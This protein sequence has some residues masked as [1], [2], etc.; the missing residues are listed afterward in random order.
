MSSY[1]ELREELDKAFL[2]IQKGKWAKEDHRKV[3]AEI[4]K[5]IIDSLTPVL[6]TIATNSRIS[7]SELRKILSE[8][9]F[10]IPAPK[11]PDIDTSSI[12]DAITESIEAAFNNINIPAPQVDVKVPT[13][14]VSVQVPE[15]K[16]PQINIP[17]VNFP[18]VM[19]TEIMGV[20]YGK[21]LPVILTDNKGNPYIAGSLGGVGGSGGGKSIITDILGSGGRSV[22]DESANAI[23]VTG[24]NFNTEQLS[25]AIDSINVVQ[26]NSLSSG[27]GSG[28]DNSG[29]L[30]VVN[31]TDVGTSVNVTGFTGSIGATILNGDGNSLD[32]RDRNW[33]ITETVP[34]SAGSTLDVKQV[35]GANW[36]FEIASQPFTLDTKQ[37]SGSIDSMNILSS[38]T[39]D[40][41]QLSGSIDSVLVTGFNTSIGASI[42]NGDGNAIDPRDRNWTIIET[43][44]ISTGST[45]DVKQVS[46]ANWSIEITSQPFTL[47]TKQV[48]GSI[49]SINILSSVTLD[50]KQVSGS[51]DSTNVTQLGGNDIALNSGVV[52][53]GT[54]R[55]VQVTDVASSI[56]V[57]GAN[58]TIITNIANS[59]GATLDPR[60][61]NWTITETIP[62]S[63]GSTLDVKQV[64]GANWSI[65]IASQPFTLDTK[66]VSGGVDSISIASQP[67]T[68]DVKQVSGSIDSI[69]VLQY[70]GTG[71]AVGTEDGAGVFRVY[72]VQN[73]VSSI[74]VRQINGL[75]TGFGSGVDNTGVLRVVNVTDVAT[76]VNI[77]AQDI[78]LAVRQVSGSV[79]SIEITSQ[80]FSL[81]IRQVSGS[82]FSTEITSQ[83]FTL[84]VKQVSGATDSVSVI[85]TVAVT[86]STTPW[87]NNITQV[88]SNPID[89]NAGDASTG[90]L[91]T[92]LAHSVNSTTAA[93]SIGADAS[94]NLVLT[95]AQRKS[96]MFTHVST[97][98]LYIST[99][100]AASTTSFPVVANQIVGFEDYTGPVNA[101]AEEQAGTISVRYIEVA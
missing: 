60:D 82:V 61:R 48:S 71:V 72:Q 4:S 94:T 40:I 6:E 98:N 88:G 59:D 68:L 57:T 7:Q 84:D 12:R 93:V 95:T 36:S 14:K 46:G 37:L 86:Q 83:P 28:V 80:P 78:T 45:L 62:I 16:L 81:D 38:V 87:V 41:K 91:R 90:T 92:I 26:L 51:S 101:I 76:S 55:T 77:I 52:N 73:A 35:S 18:S 67:F 30:R 19:K 47:D 74:D 33:S 75:T 5:D 39:L 99:G 96:V 43:V 3:V 100:T 22:I 97:S 58:G 27:F 64:S 20:N 23:K 44:P 63:T 32:P 53:T 9:K 49:D 42:L 70:G 1:N 69:N 34:I 2:Q 29:V 11:I 8:M 15:I 13:P 24:A 56:Y 50:V 65:E 54:I 89:V 66:Q 85:G 17:P 21:P 31:V 79:D 10:D 25:G